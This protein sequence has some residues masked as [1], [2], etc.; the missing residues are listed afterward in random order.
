MG[1]ICSLAL[2]LTEEAGCITAGNTQWECAMVTDVGMGLA[3]LN[4]ELT[5]YSALTQIKMRKNQKKT[6]ETVTG[7]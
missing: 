2:I 4:A 3:L 5:L 1:G 7:G 6:E